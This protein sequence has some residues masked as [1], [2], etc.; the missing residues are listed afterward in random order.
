MENRLFSQV[1]IVPHLPK[2]TPQPESYVHTN[3]QNILCTSV[4]IAR[5]DI[6]AEVSLAVLGL[7]Y[8]IA[9]FF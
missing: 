5:D 9:V 7:N 2:L 1:F 8:I 4:S 3:F 6:Y